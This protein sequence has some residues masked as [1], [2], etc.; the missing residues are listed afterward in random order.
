MGRFMLLKAGGPGFRLAGAAG[1][2]TGGICIPG[3]CC[4][5]RNGFNIE[6][7]LRKNSPAKIK[8]RIILGFFL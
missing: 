3:R 1:K 8:Y 5:I 7:T 2:T 6:F 4:I